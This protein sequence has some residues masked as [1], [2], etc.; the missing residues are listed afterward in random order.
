MNPAEVNKA[1]IL[2]RGL[3]TRMRRAQAGADRLD[4]RQAHMADQGIKAMIPV[5]RPFLDY[6]LSGLADAGCRN[7]CLVIGPEHEIIPEYYTRTC[8]PTRLRITFAIQE[9]P[10]GTADALAA[11]RSFAGDDHF[12]TLN[13]D[14]YYPI[15][16]LRTLRLLG[17]PGLAAFDRNSLT[18]EGNISSHRIRQFAVITADADGCLRRIVEK[19]EDAF[20]RTLEPDIQVSMNCW[21]FGPA[22]FPA[23]ASVSPSQRGELELT[24]AVQYAMTHLAERFRVLKFNAGVL[25]LSNRADIETVAERLREIEVKL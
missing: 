3:G 1:V 19:P 7:V 17:R 12:L 2:A 23:C 25:D 20:L 21:L 4:S 11:A 24:D 6:V 16:A 15:S 8:P 22:I 18:R 13:S 14:N 5:G 10:R 9:H